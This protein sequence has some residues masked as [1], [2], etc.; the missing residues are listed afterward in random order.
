MITLIST[1]AE[2][3]KEVGAEGSCPG[4]GGGGVLLIFLG[5]LCRSFLKTPIQTIIYDFPYAISDLT[6]K[7]YTLFQTP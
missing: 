7:M 1:T 2:N 4:G 5:G 3:T 6:L